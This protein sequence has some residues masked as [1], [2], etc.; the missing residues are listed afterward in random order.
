MYDNYLIHHG[1]EGQKWGVRKYQNEDGSLTSAGRARYGEGTREGLR[2][3]T[4]AGGLIGRAIYKKNHDMS[5]LSKRNQAVSARAQKQQ[6]P[7]VKEKKV[8]NKPSNKS[9]VS[10][11]NRARRNKK[12]GE[13]VASS[14]ISTSFGVAGVAVARKYSTPEMA[15]LCTG[16]LAANSAMNV[17]TVAL[18]VDNANKG[19][20][21]K[22]PRS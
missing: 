10:A 21:D 11:E 3:A 6:K 14:I 4:L 13:A 18:T 17:A 5:G 19:V 7:I 20:Y 16:L 8:S 9:T 22:K 15:K 2:N 1:I 12:I